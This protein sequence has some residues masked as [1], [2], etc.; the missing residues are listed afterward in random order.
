[1]AHDVLNRRAVLRAL[2]GVGATA[3]LPM[4]VL[5]QPD[6]VAALQ[7]G[8]HVVYFRHAATTRSGVD[9]IEWPRSRQRLLSE[10]GIA[11]SEAIGAAFKAL[12]IPVG[13]VL[14][15][16]FARCADMARIAF[17]RV[18]TRME[19]LG[20]LSDRAGREARVAYLAGLFSAPPGPEGNRIV[21]SHRSNIATVA[22]VSLAEGDAAII[23]P[24]G[25]GHTVLAT[26]SPRD[27][28]AI[29]G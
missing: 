28:V 4:P 5:A 21:I 11:D 2:L 27:W 1:M 17:G 23:R 25:N 16:P 14:A 20:L 9:R 15:S 26:L 6:I 29:G 7:R 8:G 18:E 13:D 24:D 19:L 3:L 12:D 10:R 22:G